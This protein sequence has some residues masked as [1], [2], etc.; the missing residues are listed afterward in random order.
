MNPCLLWGLRNSGL[1][2]SNSPRPARKSRLHDLGDEKI[3]QT[4]L[5]VMSLLL[6]LPQ[7]NSGAPG[8]LPAPGTMPPRLHCESRLFEQREF[9]RHQRSVWGMVTAGR[10]HPGLFVTFE[11]KSRC[12]IGYDCCIII[13]YLQAYAWYLAIKPRFNNILNIS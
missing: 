13:C 11:R 1:W 6:L 3:P 10:K 8:Y 4:P 2:P 5:Y 7:G 12:N 9:R